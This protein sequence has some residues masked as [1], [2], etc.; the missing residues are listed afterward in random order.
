MTAFQE[1]CGKAWVVCALGLLAC[2]EK[3]PLPLPEEPHRVS[4]TSTENHFVSNAIHL[5]AK[6]Q[7]CDN[8][9]QA[10]L[11]QENAP[12]TEIHFEKGTALITLPYK[13]FE[14]FFP[15]LGIEAHL[16][17]KA[18]V[19]CEN[20][21][22]SDSLPI[23]VSFFPV[24]STVERKNAMQSFTA[25][26]GAQGTPT[27]FLGCPQNPMDNLGP[28]L[29]HFDKQ[30]NLLG[31][32]YTT[33][34]QCACNA[35]TQINDALSGLRWAY[36]PGN[37]AESR[38][39]TLFAFR[40]NPLHLVS[41]TNST[42]NSSQSC[43][44]FA[45]DSNGNAFVVVVDRVG[46][47]LFR[48]SIQG[49]QSNSPSYNSLAEVDFPA[50]PVVVGDTLL[51]PIW[52]VGTGTLEVLRFDISNP[53]SG[54]TLTYLCS[55]DNGPMEPSLPDCPVTPQLNSPATPAAVLSKDGTRLY[56][57][58]R[59]AANNAF[60]ALYNLN[61]PNPS[62][63][64]IHS[65]G[66]FE[67]PITQ[68]SLSKNER[69]LV[70]STA[71]TTYF[72]STNPSADTLG[73]PLTVSGSLYVSKHIHGPETDDSLILLGLPF[74]QETRSYGW[75]LEAIAVDK[76]ERGELWRF[77]YRGDGKLPLSALAVSVDEGGQMWMRMG[78]QLVNPLPQNHYR[79]LR[80]TPEF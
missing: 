52:R 38:A 43:N 15:K 19:Q 22:T 21:R 73:P 55:F 7:G 5:I 14:A 31:Q 41:G 78:L 16:N 72:F 68:L 29:E 47:Q 64:H 34:L 13:A 24:E 32:I 26:G 37:Y 6:V 56:V 39:C 58:Q 65:W 54:T 79:Q 10:Q 2:G 74:F 69:F 11:L 45:T 66:P 30:G 51:L 75:P 49:E 70:A 9:T 17:L 67:S 50:P 28:F 27:T 59:N 35:F 23:G 18:R 33:P 44:G 12:V 36:T 57:A 42:T 25:I 20:G 61:P 8:I 71:R 60:V 48:I 3:K 63:L 53:N 62:P 4:L 80:G 76:P 40:D 1:Y 77:N 46:F